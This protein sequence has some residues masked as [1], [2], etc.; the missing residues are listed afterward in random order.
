MR[1]DVAAVC[2]IICGDLPRAG[3]QRYSAVPAEVCGMHAVL[4]AA[5]GGLCCDLPR[6]GLYRNG[7]VPAYVSGMRADVGGFVTAEKGA[8]GS[9]GVAAVV[10]GEAGVAGSGGVAILFVDAMLKLPHLAMHIHVR[11]CSRVGR[12]PTDAPLPDP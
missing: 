4:A 3:L 5:C 8:A 2:G 1:A 10:V 11:E 6:A 7:A 9:G 12:S